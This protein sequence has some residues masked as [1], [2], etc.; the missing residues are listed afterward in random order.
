MATDTP[1]TPTSEPV[2]ALAASAG[3]IQ[4]LTTILRALPRDLPAAVVVVQ[5]P[6]ATRRQRLQG[7]TQ[8]ATA[9]P[10]I[11]AQD[12]QIIQPGRVYVARSDLHLM[13]SPTKRF[14]NM[15]GNRIRFLLSSAN[16]LFESAAA[17]FKSHLVAVVL[18]GMGSDAPTVCRA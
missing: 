2:I 7:N 13:V 10:V 11:M 12:D 15:N 5:A 14:H 18:T 3:G 4:A 17:A 9:M 8:R 6:T 1:T 16:P